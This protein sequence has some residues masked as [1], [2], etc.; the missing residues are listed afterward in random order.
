MS[1]QR[2]RYLE[3]AIHEDLAQ[4]MVFLAGP[5]QIGKTTLAKMIGGMYR[6]PVCLNWDNRAHRKAILQ[7]QWKPTS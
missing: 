2:Q 5:R 1:E 4:K 7:Q 6:Q 3:S